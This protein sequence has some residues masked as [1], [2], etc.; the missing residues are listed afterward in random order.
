MS[1]TLKYISIQHEL[2][3]AIG[4]DLRLRPMLKRFTRVCI[5][6][7][8]LA[9]VHFHLLQNAQG[10]PLLPGTI[11]NG[12]LR[13]LLSVPDVSC[14]WLDSHLN[15]IADQ[16]YRAELPYLASEELP[17]SIY[18][19]CFDIAGF[20]I[21][22]LVRKDKP[23]DAVLLELLRPIV[24]RLAVSAQASIEH[25]LLLNAIDARK[26]AEETIVFQLMHDELT[27]LPNRKLLMQTLSQKIEKSKMDQYFGAVLFIDLDRFKVVNDT[28]GHSVGDQLLRA[29]A[30]HLQA[31]VQEQGIVARLSGDEF[32]VLLDK[33]GSTH[34]EGIIQVSEVVEEIRAGFS[35]PIR[36]GEHLL[37]ITPSIGIELFP[38]GKSTAAQI[39]RHADTAMYQAKTQGMNNAVFYDRQLSSELEQ[40]LEIEKE[41]QAALKNLEQFELYYQPQYNAQSQCIGAEALIRWIHPQ[42]GIVRPDLFIPVAE[43]TGLM[44][45]LGDWVLRQ[46][47][48]QIKFL[49]EQTLPPHFERISVN[50]SP[51]QFNQKD[52]VQRLLST[53]HNHGADTSLLAIELTEST[54]I[55]NVAETVNK[56]RT[57]REAGI[58]VSVDDFG[59]GYSSLSY[60][61]R[62]P[63]ETLK[64]DQ[65]F[66][67]DI[68][69]DQ[70]NRAIVETI[71]ALAKS[72]GLKLIA[73]GVETEDE[74]KCLIEVGCEHFQ[75][76]HFSRPV[77]FEEFYRS[78]IS[79]EQE[80]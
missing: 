53:I 26:I 50:V 17:G 28:L 34:S 71:V 32:V 65:A 45:E 36:A 63:I 6:R 40:R 4:L 35:Q 62:F 37:H 58:I 19:H 23:I 60:L 72:L 3:M 7:L 38:D 77:N 25:E 79:L 5:R 61:N 14:D 66:V 73:E 44:L 57:L 46:A 48:Q 75:G 33:L 31:V 39:L 2:G 78:L 42:R 22:S 59:T 12:E 69:S 56:I 13:H 27:K 15:E 68:H 21:V 74:I 29:V 70:G 24:S 51:V 80:A 76:Y 10:Q 18:L 52:F 9:S 47:C 30:L 54:L 67:R 49:Q 41:L 55:S 43:E 11:D 8:G 16:L 64:V 20:G 1:N